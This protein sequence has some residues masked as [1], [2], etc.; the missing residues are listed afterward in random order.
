MQAIAKEDVEASGGSQ[1][2]LVSA[3][4]RIV[5]VEA[6]RQ[7]GQGIRFTWVDR[8]ALIQVCVPKSQ[9]ADDLGEMLTYMCE[10]TTTPC[11][12]GHR[13]CFEISDSLGRVW[14]CY[15]VEEGIL[16]WS[17][18]PELGGLQHCQ[19]QDLPARLSLSPGQAEV[20]G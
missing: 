11:G 10:E 5:A 6:Q 15:Q 16:D 1:L 7:R 13:N 2:V 8:P 17:S 9:P 3:E 4:G 18:F 19:R 20:H 14:Q 12:G